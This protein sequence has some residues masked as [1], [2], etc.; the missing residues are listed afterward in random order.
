MLSLLLVALLGAGAADGLE[1]TFPGDGGF[2][3]R[4]RY[5]AGPDGGPGVLLLHQCDREGPHTGYEKLAPGLAEAGVHALA[6]DFRGYGRSVDVRFTGEN[7]QE[8]RTHFPADLEAALDYLE[9]R[10]GIDRSRIGVVGASC[11]GRHAVLLAHSH[12]EMRALVLLSA[13]LGRDPEALVE[14]IADRPLFCSVAEEDPFGPTVESLK[15]AFVAS[16]HPES[17]LVLYKG[18]AHGTPLLEGDPLLGAAI[19]GWL[20]DRLGVR[21]S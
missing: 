2:L 11:G 15:R 3:L 13:G 5:H 6:L 18:A 1:V 14:P 19:T 9:S 12:G 7:W 4:A 16:G 10:P 8:A 17:R 21:G 20:R